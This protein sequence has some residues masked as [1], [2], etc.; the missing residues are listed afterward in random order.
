MFQTVKSVVDIVDVARHYGLDPDRKGW[1]RC[2][3]HGEK[4]ASFHLYNQRYR[5]FGCGASGDAIDLVAAMRNEDPLEA[6][7]ELNAVLGLGIDLD[8]PVDTTELAKARAERERRERFKRWRGETVRII[9]DHHR[10]LHRT[11]VHG[12][13]NS[14]AEI[15]DRCARALVEIAQVEY[16]ANLSAF[17]EEDEVRA[18]APVLDAVVNRIKRGEGKA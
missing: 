8:A 10:D 13:A 14:A 17:G 11:I 2:P 6:V 9:S 16:Y 1:C 18:A 15:S 12:A 7:R 5:C 3:F 4:T